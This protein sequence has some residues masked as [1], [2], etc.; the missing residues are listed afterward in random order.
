M[1]CAGLFPAH[2]EEDLDMMQMTNMN[3]GPLMMALGGFSWLV[4][5]SLVGS[6]TVLVW[7]VIGRLRRTPP[8]V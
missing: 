5:L 4:G 2:R 3:C 1:D 8:A 6:L 7:V